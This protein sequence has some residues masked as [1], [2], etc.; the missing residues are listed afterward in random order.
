[1]RSLGLRG[2]ARQRLSG[3]ERRSKTRKRPGA[4][5]IVMAGGRGRE[6]LCM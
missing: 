3:Y 4:G 1:M 2:T 5:W 6:R